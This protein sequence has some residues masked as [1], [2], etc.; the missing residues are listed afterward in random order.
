MAFVGDYLYFA[1]WDTETSAWITT[2]VDDN[3]GMGSHA[4]LAMDT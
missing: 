4:S 1:K 3:P 2:T